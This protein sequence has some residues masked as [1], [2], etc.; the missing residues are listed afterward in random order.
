MSVVESSNV[1]NQEDGKPGQE[2][3]LQR[4]VPLAVWGLVILTLVLTVLR[5]I[6]YGLVPAGDARRHIAK[7]FTDKS[8]TDILV[9]RPEY[10]MDHSPGW[11]WLL[12]ALHQALGWDADTLAA[13]S[14]ASTLLLL[15]LA[16]LPWLRRPEAWMGAVLAQLVALPSIMVRLVQGRPYLLTEAVLIAILV[17]WAGSRNEKTPSRLKMGLTSVGIAFSVWMHGAWYLWAIPPAAFFL[18]GWWR[19]SLRLAGC[20]AAGTLAGAMLTG[21]PFEFLKQAL[22]IA[23]VISR[24]K[25]P[26]SL[27]VGEFRPTNGDFSTLVLLSLTFL[28]YSRLKAADGPAPTG[29]VFWQII[30]AWILGLHADRFWSDWG[31]P[32]VMA[33]LALRGEEMISGAWAPSAHRRLLA[34]ALLGLA[35]YLNLGAD[36]NSRY[37]YSNSEPFPDARRPDLAGWFPERG[38]ILYTSHM[39][40]FYNTFYQNPEGEWR[41]IVGMEPALMP[42]ED[43]KIFRQIQISNYSYQAYEPWVR[44]MRPAD[45]LLLQSNGKPPLPQLE[46]KHVE[47]N[48]WIGRIPKDSAAAQTSAPQ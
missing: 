18:A 3:L 2:T 6:S 4:Y 17:A 12:R 24:E 8:Y 22:L 5:I 32:A 23:A 15:L 46:W 43:L 40:L 39:H 25:V 19:S 48:L 33:W 20:V 27:L 29:P 38:G 36:R 28:W 26:S 11:E 44:K 47:D 30:L 1:M 21:K 37:T 41:Y 14:I 42:E 31:I 16:P 7:A 35:F 34:C 13:F 9:L 10:T 45:R